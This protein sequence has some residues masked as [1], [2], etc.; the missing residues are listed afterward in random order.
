MFYCQCHWVTKCHI[1]HGY[2]VLTDLGLPLPQQLHLFRALSEF[3]SCLLSGYRLQ[4]I[5]APRR[6]KPWS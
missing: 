6:N 4:E 2:V 3:L 5:V 1:S